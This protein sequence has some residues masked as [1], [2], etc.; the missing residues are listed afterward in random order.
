MD[1]G[2]GNPVAQ[3]HVR[4]ALDEDSAPVLGQRLGANADHPRQA[5]QRQPDLVLL[6]GHHHLESLAAL[7]LPAQSFWGVG[8][9]D[10]AFVDDEDAVAGGLDLGE[11]VGREDHG[12]LLAELA[13]QR[14][15]L[16]PLPRVEA[17]GGLVEDHDVGFVDHRLGDAHPLPEAL[18]ELADDAIGDVC[19]VGFLHRE[20]DLL[21]PAFAIDAS[22]P[23]HE[24]KVIVD[25]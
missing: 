11:D 16:T 24:L 10:G 12:V 2:T 19:E 5:L 13:D 25:L 17:L 7:H 8:R 20:P 18:G 22:Q 1:Q 15:G 21:L 4:L 6:G 14:P 3:F 9:H 23:G